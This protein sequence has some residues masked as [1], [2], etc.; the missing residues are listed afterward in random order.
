MFVFWRWYF[1]FNL[2]S[3]WEW[4]WTLRVHLNFPILWWHEGTWHLRRSK[5]HKSARMSFSPRSPSTACPSPG[6]LSPCFIW[7]ESFNMWLVSREQAGVITANKAERAWR[8]A[9]TG[10][11]YARKSVICWYP[12]HADRKWRLGRGFCWCA[13]PASFVCWSAGRNCAD[14]LF[15]SKL[16]GRLSFLWSRGC[17]GL[18]LL[19]IAA[20]AQHRPA[21]SLCN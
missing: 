18:Q 7:A 20:W 21:L 5:G 19:T 3:W 14:V 13:N 8:A 4:D 9:M 2:I 15:L 12:R 10:G 16:F 6:N 17:A 11:M 1:S